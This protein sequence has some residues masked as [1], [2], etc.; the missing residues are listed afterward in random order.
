MN[1]ISVFI[2]HSLGE[3]DILLPLFC[4]LQEKNDYKINFY[5]T[6]KKI[7]SKFIENKFYV[8]FCQK[9]K[10]EVKFSPLYNKFDYI[11]KNIKNK[12]FHRIYKLVNKLY[13][14][15]IFV[16]NNFEIFNSK[17]IMNDGSTNELRN[18]LVY[19]ILFKLL[20]KNNYVYFHGHAL[21]Q[22]SKL[23][24]KVKIN[25]NATAL[26]FDESILDF[27]KQKG[28]KKISVIGFPKF[29]KSWLNVIRSDNRFDLI[30][31]NYIVIYSRN[32][33]HKYYMDKDIY[34]SL[35]KETYLCIR[36]FFPSYKI[37]IK[38]HPRED[39]Q[40]LKKLIKDNNYE[41]IEITELHST[42]LAKKAK[43]IVSF[44]TSAILDS[45][46]LNVPSVEFY[47][48][49]K[50]FRVLEP[51]GSLY[52]VMGI[53]SVDNEKDLSKFMEKVIANKY[54]I[55]EIVYKFKRKKVLS[56]FHDNL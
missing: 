40:F 30:D 4:E 31:R 53:D 46:S 15:L 14:D 50:N 18:S 19:I 5:V 6:S 27:W 51:N 39:E 43:M 42:I 11:S 35:I 32:Y 13:L 21:N 20:K 37:L 10:I 17:I 29:Y 34:I 33:E 1:K 2:T 36:K 52:K 44:W 48:E 56:I 49:A 38:T 55:P 16:K 26:S 22:P 3:F 28:Y 25:K 45:L 47:K 8:D 23:K 9:L 41:N 7:N 24:Q 12:I 54:S